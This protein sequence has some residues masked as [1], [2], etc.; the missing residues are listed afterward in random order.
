MLI[1]NNAH[2]AHILAPCAHAINRTYFVTSTFPNFFITK[3][4]K[5]FIMALDFNKLAK[6]ALDICFGG[7]L[8]WMSYIYYLY[9]F[10]VSIIVDDQ[11][12]APDSQLGQVISHIIATIVA[13]VAK[14][15]GTPAASLVRRTL[16]LASHAFAIRFVYDNVPV[17]EDAVVN[18]PVIEEAEERNSTPGSV[19]SNLSGQAY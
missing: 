12:I 4:V 14:E 19:S 9:R 15:I 5:F 13:L 16:E 8:I 10:K 2:C 6:F 7:L 18:A 11:V 17:V 3:V 1:S